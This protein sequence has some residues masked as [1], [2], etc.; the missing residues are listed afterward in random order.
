MLTTEQIRLIE[1]YHEGTLSSTEK[2]EVENTIF[3]NAELK[4]EA[5]GILEILDGFKAIKFEKFQQN[6]LSWEQKHK[7]DILPS[8]EYSTVNQEIKIFSLKDFIKKYRFAVAAVVFALIL[9]LGYFVVSNFKIPS[10]ENLY[11]SNAE[12]FNI[13]SNQTRGNTNTDSLSLLLESGIALYNAQKYS[14]A[15]KSLYEYYDK[16]EDEKKTSEVK[17]YIGLSNLFSGNTNNAKVYFEAIIQTGKADNFKDGAE[18]YLALTYLKEMNSKKSAELLQ[19]IS[20]LE[21][22]PYRE[23]AIVLLPEVQR[24]KQ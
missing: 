10:P 19:S 7:S 20:S 9:P 15:A 4:A 6:L 22:H 18:W 14:E 17:L 8:K 5:D 12:H 21:N 3:N 13:F 16:I 23:K 11:A 1:L 24:L 2:S